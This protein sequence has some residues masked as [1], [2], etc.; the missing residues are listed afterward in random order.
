MRDIVITVFI[1]GAVP[2]IVMRP[3]LGVLMVA[4]LSLMTP[5]RFTF[6]FAHDFPFVYIIAVCTMVGLLVTKDEVR[7][8]PDTVLVLLILLP[9]WTCVTYLFSFEPEAGF[10]RLVEVA[11]V[12]L[13]IHISAMVLRTRSQLD[14][15]LWVI[16]ISVGFY[17][18]KGGV[19]TILTGGDSRVYGP[20][21]KSFLSDNNSIAVA[22]IMV[23]PLMYYL[24]S[25]ATS[26]WIRNGLIVSMALSGM[27]I[28]GTY[29]RGALLA[30]GV[31]LIF[32][33]SKSKR[34]LILALLLIPLVP[35]GVTFMPD[36][37][38]D[39][40]SSISG[41]EE[42]GSA[43]GRINAWKTAINIANDRPL[44][45]GGFELYT[46]ETFSRYS[47]DPE[48][49]HSAHSIYFQMLGEHG[50]VGLLIFLGLFA[51][52]WVTARRIIA[53]SRHRQDLDWA[54]N[55][56]R[57]FQVSLVGYAVGG[58]FV[59]IGYWDLVYYEIVIVTVAYRLAS[60]AEKPAISAA[61]NPGGGV[62]EPP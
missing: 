10:P 44:V 56:A 38:R 45:G 35:A 1:L 57:A 28:L 15:M 60:E 12:F 16:V 7:Y 50:Y 43:M 14:W 36:Q 55:F 8:Q 31:M 47:P 33:W 4:W 25:V 3:W 40:M 62:F 53:L 24:R 58:C 49:I 21:G 2:F 11:K 27:A 22:L 59:N 5:Y 48:D 32:L 19:F 51:A 17:G 42:D 18:V 52:A 37:W 41:Y 23:I 29:S 26:L 20:P 39:R 6:G 30:V 61:G 54:E 9:A 46:A 13:F 34:K